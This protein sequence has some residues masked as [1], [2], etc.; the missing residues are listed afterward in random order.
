MQNYSEIILF[1][2]TFMFNISNICIGALE[3]EKLNNLVKLATV[4]SLAQT[5]ISTVELSVYI[6]PTLPAPCGLRTGAT[7]CR[8]RYPRPL[9]MT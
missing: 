9:P 8:L 7:L 6:L 5:I 4:F 3:E 1:E 2:F